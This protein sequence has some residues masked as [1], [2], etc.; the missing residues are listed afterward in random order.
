MLMSDIVGR[1]RQMV[2][3]GLA[4]YHD[5]GICAELNGAADEIERQRSRIRELEGGLKE[6]E[7]Y[8]TDSWAKQRVRSLTSS[9]KPE[10]S[11]N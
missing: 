1:I 10:Q 2:R 3:D 8:T 6:L 4:G 11:R 7:F 9:T 5:P